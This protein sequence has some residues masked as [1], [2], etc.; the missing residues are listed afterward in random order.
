MVVRA[1]FFRP[2]QKH[3]NNL[4]VCSHSHTL[5]PSCLAWKIQQLL[6]FTF[7]VRRDLKHVGLFLYYRWFYVVLLLKHPGV[8]TA[9]CD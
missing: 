2:D 4:D 3:S 7:D 1:Q 6:Y 8:D 9:T 5:S